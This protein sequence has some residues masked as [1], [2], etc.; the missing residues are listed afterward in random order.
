ML[1]IQDIVKVFPH[2]G[3]WVAGLHPHGISRWSHP[4]SLA[5]CQRQIIMAIAARTTHS[6]TPTK[7]NNAFIHIVF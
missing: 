6:F 7:L 1:A 3:L 2:K 4:S 5:G